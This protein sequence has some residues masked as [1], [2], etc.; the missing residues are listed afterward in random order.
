M[1]RTEK[2]QMVGQY[3]LDTKSDRVLLVEDFV[4]D[5]I[6]GDDYFIALDDK[7]RSV[8]IDCEDVVLY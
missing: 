2:K 1:T 5:G 8:I 6:L 4:E 3:V 7:S